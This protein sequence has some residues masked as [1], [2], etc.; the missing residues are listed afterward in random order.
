MNPRIIFLGTGT[1]GGVPEIGCDC[2]VCKSSDPRDRRLRSSAYVETG[3]SK[4]LIDA[5]PDFRAQ[6]LRHDIRRVDAL[7]VTHSHYDHIGG[8]DELRQINWLMGKPVD[9]YGNAQT[10][11]EIRERFA[12][13]FRKTTPVGGGLPK[14]ELHDVSVGQTF[15]AADTDVLPVEVLHGKTSILGYVVGKLAYITDASELPLETLDRLREA[16][17]SVLVL[18]ALRYKPHS[19]HFNLEQALE[20]ASKIRAQRTYF[21]HFT[22]NVMQSVIE[23]ELPANVFA[24]YDGLTVEY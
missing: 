8:I 18:N 22:H 6:A 2:P 9:V 3:D 10:T 12:Y 15:R 19:T 14:L 16:G 13:I 7:L 20:T 11:A 4:F 23:K 21:I 1:S 5:G 24:A 17:L